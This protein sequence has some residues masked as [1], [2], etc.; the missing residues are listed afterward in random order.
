MRHYRRAGLTFDVHDAGPAD[1]D[2]VVLLHGFPQGASCWRDVVPALHA[3]GFRTLAPDQRGY[4][5]RA[6]PGAT[7]A[8]R[9]RELVDDVLALLDAAEAPR[10]HVVGHDWGGGVAWVLGA[11]APDR[12]RTLAVVSTPH[13]AAMRGSLLHGQ[14]LR[15]WYMGLFQVPWLAERLLAP[16]GR[17]WSAVRDD[18]PDDFA[19]G[20]AERMRDRA[21]RTAALAWYRAIPAEVTRPSV[22][23]GPVDVPTLYVWGDRD[24]ALGAAAARATRECVRGPYRF[25]VLAG[26]GHW[27]PET[28]G[29]ELAVL[30]LEHLGPPGEST[31]R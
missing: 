31:A 28:R 10:A 20:Y 2:P 8:Y 3:A 12:V 25:E 16:D 15:S 5:P 11:T 9:W 4:S 23:V 24:P 29:P 1:G 14:L 7:S 18:L 26:A 6:R 30:L 22:A 19:A 13:P 17:F 27:I 21:A